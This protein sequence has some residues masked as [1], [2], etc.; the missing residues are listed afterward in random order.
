MAKKKPVAPRS[1]YSRVKLKP[2]SPPPPPPHL[3]EESFW[4]TPGPNLRKMNITGDLLLNENVDLSDISMA[5]FGTPLPTRVSAT[6]PTQLARTDET[7]DDLLDGGAFGADVHDGTLQ[8]TPTAPDPP[9]LQ[10]P[11]PR[12]P[13]LQA[14]VPEPALQTPSTNGEPSSSKKHK[15]RVTS[16]T[17]KIVVGG[18]RAMIVLYLTDTTRLKYGLPLAKSSCLGIKP[19]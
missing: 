12:P 5:S 6:P 8:A 2:P 9:P 13:Q 10:S 16:D 3:Q 4:N 19:M 11:S 17:G 14:V 1:S 15:L 18:E 7:L